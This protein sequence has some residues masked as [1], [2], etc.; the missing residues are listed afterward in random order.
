MIYKNKRKVDCMKSED[1][2]IL[3]ICYDFDKTLSPDDMQAQGYIQSID[4]EVAD[5]WKADDSLDAVIKSNEDTKVEKLNKIITLLTSI[6]SILQPEQNTEPS[7]ESSDSLPAFNP[8]KGFWKWC[9]ACAM[10][11][12]RGLYHSPHVRAFLKICGVCIVCILF[13]LFGLLVSE[14]SRLRTDN[15]RMV[16]YLMQQRGANH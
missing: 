14:N 3:A 6:K 10:Y 15:Q 12:G 8:E 13:F 7:P 1:K 2:P 4:Y 11:W 16:Q 5:F 9:G